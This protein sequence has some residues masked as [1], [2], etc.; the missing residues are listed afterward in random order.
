T[1][2]FDEAFA[3][4]LGAR[5]QHEEKHASVLNSASIS[6]TTPAIPLGPCGAFPLNLLT[7]SLTPTA[8][9]GCPLA[10]VNANFSHGTDLFTWNATGEY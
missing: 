1:Y 4:T 2:H 3:L 8:L 10:P 9:P 7:A 6:P 5:I